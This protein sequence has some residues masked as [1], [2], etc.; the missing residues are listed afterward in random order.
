MEQL[1]KEINLQLN[2][3]KRITNIDADTIV[4]N[5]EDL[6]NMKMQLSL[7]DKTVFI[8]NQ[9]IT[10]NGCSVIKSEDVKKGYVKVF[11]DYTK[12]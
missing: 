7:K 12:L 3:F 10:Y 11:K 8:A 2:N 1:H 9:P 4:L 6:I 5:I